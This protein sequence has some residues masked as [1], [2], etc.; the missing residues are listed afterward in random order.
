S[1]HSDWH[2]SPGPHDSLSILADVALVCADLPPRCSYD[3]PSPQT[4]YQL[5]PQSANSLS[6]NDCRSIQTERRILDSDATLK[7]VIVESNTHNKEA[8][9]EHSQNLDFNSTSNL[10]SDELLHNDEPL[11][12]STTPPRSPFEEFKTSSPTFINKDI[13]VCPECDRSYSTS[14]NLARHRQTHR[15]PDDKKAARRC[16]FCA[17]VYVSTPAFSQHMRTHNQ[18]CKCQTCG[19]TFSRPWLL[20]G[21]IR[22]HTGEKPF[23]CNMCGKAFADKSNLRAHI[24]THSNIKPFSC[25]RCGK[26]FALKSYL[27]KHEESS[28]CTKAHKYS[29][30]ISANQHC[31]NSYNL[32]SKSVGSS[33]TKSLNPKAMSTPTIVSP[34]KTQIVQQKYAREPFI[35]TQISVFQPFSSQLST[36]IVH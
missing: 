6:Q 22:T 1:E 30:Q 9:I 23:K 31:R 20:Q 27:Y 14:S 18:G 28:S 8:I 19:K 21:H 26:S 33:P 34:L 12:L 17:K 25:L 29:D 7:T 4:I 2:L 36:T 3:S 10:T 11:N 16:P 24:Q 5:I 15:S 13:Y 32:N 35:N